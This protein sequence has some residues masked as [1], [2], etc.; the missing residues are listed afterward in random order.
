MSTRSEIGIQNKNGII[1]SVYCHWDGY[2][3]H[4]GLLLYLYYN[5]EEKV[6]E[7]IKNGDLS[8][9]GEKIEPDKNKEHSFNNPQKD[10]CI[11]YHRDR[12]ENWEQVKP[13]LDRCNIKIW[14]ESLKN[15]WQDYGYLFKNGKWYFL[16]LNE[17]KCSL[18]ELSYKILKA[19]LKTFDRTEELKLLEEFENK[20]AA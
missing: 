16:D 1:E 11:Y 12:K 10:V 17:A 5:T 13:R 9:L 20:K 4:N 8:C 18:K 3:A 7:L 6:R 19:E 15:G 2:L 14:A